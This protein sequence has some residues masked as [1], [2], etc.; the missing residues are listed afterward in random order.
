MQTL[1]IFIPDGI[2]YVQRNRIINCKRDGVF[3]INKHSVII[4]DNMVEGNQGC[5]ISTSV[6]NNE[7]YHSMKKYNNS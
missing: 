4:N 6:S 5:G 3:I 1:L 7:F 2:V